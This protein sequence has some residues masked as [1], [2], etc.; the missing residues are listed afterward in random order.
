MTKQA[1]KRDKFRKWKNR[2]NKK[3]KNENNNN[4]TQENT[5]CFEYEFIKTFIAKEWRQK[6][7]YLNS[8]KLF[9]MDLESITILINIC[10]NISS[11][12]YLQYTLLP[13]IYTINN[14]NIDIEIKINR[15]PIF[16]AG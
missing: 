10:K 6:H 5:N 15:P 9:L 11:N 2:T 16:I 8:I 13:W 12:S 1:K 4:N 7:H 14:N 3:N